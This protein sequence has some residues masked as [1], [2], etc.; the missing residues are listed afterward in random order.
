MEQDIHEIKSDVKGL[1]RIVGQH[2]KEIME[3]K[4][5]IA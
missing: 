4:A 2:S 3:L 1:K 5:R